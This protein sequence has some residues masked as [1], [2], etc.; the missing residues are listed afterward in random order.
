M[1]FRHIADAE[2]DVDP[3]PA[4][5]APAVKDISIE[6]KIREGRRA[7]LKGGQEAG[8]VGFLNDWQSLGRLGQLGQVFSHGLLD[9]A[10][11]H[12]ARL[13]EGER[14]TD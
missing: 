1:Q 11:A 4:M 2:G 9:G 14:S 7:V 10:G 13:G 3:L 12:D 5:L 8:V 6:T